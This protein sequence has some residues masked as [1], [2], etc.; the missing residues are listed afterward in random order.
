MHSLN[1]ASNI[2]PPEGVK[3][4]VGLVGKSTLQSLQVEKQQCQY[5]EED[6]NEIF[7]ALCDSIGLQAEEEGD[8][9]KTSTSNLPPNL[10]SHLN[11]KLRG[12]GGYPGELG[13]KLDCASI[14][15]DFINTRSPYINMQHA[16]ELAAVFKG[17][18]SS[19]CLFSSADWNMIASME[20]GAPTWLRLADHR[21]RAMFVSQ[22]PAS[23][24]VQ[25]MEG[26]LEM[27]ADCSVD[28]VVL[29][30]DMVT[31][32][33]TGFAWVLMS[34]LASADKAVEYTNNGEAIVFGQTFV[35]SRLNINVDDDANNEA[36]A[37]ARYE[38]FTKYF[39]IVSVLVL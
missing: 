23:I 1:L 9:Y 7:T 36:E 8:S 16:T 3:K 24:T 34:D 31:K 14:N 5:E 19:K 28:E 37:K 39:Q 18:T 32:N 12:L 17:Y 21:D 15:T 38:V 13:K 30:T 10:P 26:V 33:N 27:E 20:K 35:M 29:L 4:L 11:I 6:M 25:K 2:I 22:L